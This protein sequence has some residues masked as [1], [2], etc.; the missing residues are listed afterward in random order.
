MQIQIRNPA[1]KEPHPDGET[2]AKADYFGQL[3]KNP[4]TAYSHSFFPLMFSIPGW[5]F[6][7]CVNIS[8]FPFSLDSLLYCIHQLIKIVQQRATQ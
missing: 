2:V 3:T 5:N 7:K 6:K 8:T 4:K 1:E